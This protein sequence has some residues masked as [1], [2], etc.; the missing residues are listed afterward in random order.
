MGAVGQEA[1]P[2]VDIQRIHLE[3]ERMASTLVLLPVQMEIN[4]LWRINS[5]KGM[6]SVLYASSTL[7]IGCILQLLHA[8]INSQVI[9]ISIPAHVN[10]CK[11]WHHKH[12]FGHLI[13]V[14]K[15]AFVS[16]ICWCLD[17]FCRF[18]L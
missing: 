3:K 18:R 9:A 13:L 1:R 5:V 14:Y 11:Y 17:Y 7:I 10:E 16:S 8:S 12:T 4:H 2:I 6:Y 15:H